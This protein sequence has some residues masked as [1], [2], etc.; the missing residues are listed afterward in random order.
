VSTRRCS[1]I[2]HTVRWVGTEIREPPSF[3]GLNDLEEFLTKC[4]EEVLENNRLLSLDISLKET[5]AIWWGVHKE[6]IWNWYQCKRLLCIRFGA[7]LRRNRVHKY[8]G[9][10]H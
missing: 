2:D 9:K 6:K 3:H 1:R 7:E 4:E 5:L 8:D 10:A